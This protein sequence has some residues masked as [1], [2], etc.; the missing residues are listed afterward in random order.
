MIQKT[1]TLNTGTDEILGKVHQDMKTS[2][3]IV[4]VVA[5]MFIFTTWIALQVTTQ[6]DF[7]LFN[8]IFGR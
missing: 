6:Y 2:L 7:Q 4:S 5:N 3:L 8:F 1:N